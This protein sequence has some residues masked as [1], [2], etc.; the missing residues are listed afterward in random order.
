M[1][2]RLTTAVL[3]LATTAAACGTT[4]CN[5]FLCIN[6]VSVIPKNLPSDASAV[7]ACV[8]G[9]CAGIR[10]GPPGKDRDVILEEGIHL[11]YEG[12]E[13][14]ATVSM[15]VYDNDL[16][17]QETEATADLTEGRINGSCE[18]CRSASFAYYGASNQLK[19]MND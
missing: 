16:T 9:E 11:P 18:T 17:L 2:L 3:C 7:E 10:V 4:D 19:P 5:D 13:D 1:N 15:V 12:D 6:G 8:D 14:S